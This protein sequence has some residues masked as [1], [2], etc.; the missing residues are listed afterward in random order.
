MAFYLNLF[1]LSIF[2]TYFVFFLNICT[3]FL[4]GSEI[5]NVI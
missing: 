3:S 4:F 5:V 1:V 2:M